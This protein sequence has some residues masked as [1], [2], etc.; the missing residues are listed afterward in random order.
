MGLQVPSGNTAPVYA[1]HLAAK[2]PGATWNSISSAPTATDRTT[3][4]VRHPTCGVVCYQQASASGAL[5]YAGSG[6]SVLGANGGLNTYNQAPP[7]SVFTPGSGM[8]SLVVVATGT[9]PLN[10]SLD[11][12]PF[13]ISYVQ[14]ASC[15]SSHTVW[16]QTLVATN[17]FVGNWDFGTALAAPQAQPVFAL[18]DVGVS[19]SAAGVAAAV[20][21]A[22]PTAASVAA[23]A[24]PPPWT[25]GM[26]AVSGAPATLFF[27][28]CSNV[29]HRYGSAGG[30]WPFEGGLAVDFSTTRPKMPGVFTGGVSRVAQPTASPVTTVQFPSGCAALDFGPMTVGSSFSVAFMMS[31]G[32]AIS[33]A[34]GCSS[35]PSAGPIFDLG[36][37]QLYY[38]AIAATSPVY[39]ATPAGNLLSFVAPNTGEEPTIPQAAY[40]YTV[41]T[42]DAL[43]GTK[44]YVNGMIWASFPVAALS[45][46]VWEVTRFWGTGS[47]APTLLDLQFYDYALD[48][49][50][51][52][53]MSLGIQ[54]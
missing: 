6:A 32:P 15:T 3:V 20:A 11:G 35:W 47:S 8:H 23:L 18:A 54:C 46:G 14:S 40:Q 38:T 33:T 52:R 43:A 41:V 49:L 19:T 37:F 22:Q 26:T 17:A 24:P 13:A 50:A 30:A 44:I 34:T 16:P 4:Y 31:A 42:F 45:P 12:V 21:L 7:T 28:A 51:V 36:G 10:V 2:C 1:V 27:S 53:K 5:E 9:T 39:L 29:S 25:A 48:Y